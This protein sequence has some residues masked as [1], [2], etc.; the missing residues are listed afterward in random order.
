MTA[1]S[2]T[3]SA[4]LG[5]MELL[6]VIDVSVVLIEISMAQLPTEQRLTSTRS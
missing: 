4:T 1:G 6:P 2:D 3:E 5:R